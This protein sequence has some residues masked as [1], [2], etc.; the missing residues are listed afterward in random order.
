[1]TTK[2]SD[3]L[4]NRLSAEDFDDIEQLPV[5]W[6]YLLFCCGEQFAVMMK[7]DGL[8]VPQRRGQASAWAMSSFID[9]VVGA[10][11][12]AAEDADRLAN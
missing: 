3:E 8:D 11:N 4:P 10:H 9:C 5:Q 2:L 1:M 7:E 6:Q 12:R